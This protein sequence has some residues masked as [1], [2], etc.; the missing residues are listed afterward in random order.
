MLCWAPEAAAVKA[1]RPGGQELE[2][3]GLEFGG[4]EPL[5][6]QEPSWQRGLGLGERR[7]GARPAGGELQSEHRALP[8]ALACPAWVSAASWRHA[9]PSPRAW[10]ARE[11]FQAKVNSFT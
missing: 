5:P 7:C 9:A 8:Q 6:W 3:P 1:L 2:Q 10:L 4:V 11:R